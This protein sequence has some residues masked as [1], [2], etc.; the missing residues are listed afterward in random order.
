MTANRDTSVNSAGIEF[1][2]HLAADLAQPPV[3]RDRWYWT[4]APAYAGVFLWLPFFDRLGRETVPY[5][6]WPLLVAA[7]MV[8]S[9]LCYLLLYRAPAL[10]GFRSD[11]RLSTVAAATFGTT[12]S[13]WL[14]GPAL[15]IAAVVWHAV[16]LSYSLELIFLALT[17]SRFM[18]PAQL[19]PWKLGSLTVRPPI[20]LLTLVWW[21]FI[22]RLAGKSFAHVIT[23]L[24][25]VYT[26]TALGLLV[27]TTALS[28][29]GVS[30]YRTGG[31]N[32]LSR[33][34]VE[35]DGAAI[36]PTLLLIHLIFGFFAYAGL[37]AA[38]WGRSVN[39]E[40]EVRRG[41]IVGVVASCFLTAALAI[42]TVA[43]SIGGS[44]LSE[45]D[46]PIGEQVQAAP[47][48]TFVR[49][50]D[51][52]IGGPVAAAILALFGMATLAPACYSAWDYTHQFYRLNPK[53][54]RK[55][56]AWIGAGVAFVLV[57]TYTVE[58]I[59]SIFTI[60]GAVFAPIVG[61]V[62]A[63]FMR[64]RESLREFREG[65]NPAAVAA[66]M[67]GL[68]IGLIPE[69]GRWFSL[70]TVVKIQPASLFAFVASFVTYHSLAAMGLESRSR[71][72]P[73]S[74]S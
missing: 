26:P 60:M 25:K 30:P 12:G 7:A 38:D 32:G 41:G 43:G 63:D 27:V 3:A 62:S 56:W 67:L 42:V 49:A 21:V 18:G 37:M 55:A 4:I 66:W 59:E 13:T 39:S 40:S 72:I 31:S 34:P 20:V 15:G 19:E 45:A 17:D 73:G 51:R 74:E 48:F 29:S 58:D 68:G 33:M 46:R 61:C 69:V 28:L 5:A 64:R 52:T 44:P 65:L 6:P 35:I 53:I 11:G 71:P 14:I 8:A 47:P 10:W 54:P 16:A 2:R 9:T 70:A 23:T 57:A 1:P 50:V 36:A 24:M 22:T